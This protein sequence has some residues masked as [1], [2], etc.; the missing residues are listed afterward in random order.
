MTYSLIG[1][2]PVEHVQNADRIAYMFG[3]A[4]PPNSTFVFGAVP[5]GE[6]E[7]TH[8]F[9][10]ALASQG[11]KDLVE[12]GKEGIWP[13]GVP[14]EAVGLTEETANEALQAMT[15]SFRTD[16]W[17]VDHLNEVLAANE[18]PLVRLVAEEE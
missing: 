8:M 17:G 14:F 9:Y 10:H 7:P 13:E 4:V 6:T 15:T 2:I 16:L 18:P 3:H 1:L 12:A 11:F 5:E